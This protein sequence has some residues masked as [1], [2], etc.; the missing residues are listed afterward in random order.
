MNGDSMTRCLIAL[1][2]LALPFGAAPAEEAAPPT[3]ADV[4]DL[5]RDLG[6]PYSGVR[7][8]AATRL[9]QLGPD[10][11]PAV[12]ALWRA[13]R[14]DV[15]PVREAALRALLALGEAAAKPLA[16][17]L[18]DPAHRVR[19]EG[20]LVKEAG[21][22]IVPL[23]FALT[24][25][26]SWYVRTSALA[27][28]SRVLPGNER[29]PEVLALLDD[30]SA[31]VRLAALR[32]V[33]ATKAEGDEVF[34]ALLAR[35]KDPHVLVRQAVL[36]VIGAMSEP[37]DRR[38]DLL[39]E[40]ARDADTSH[41]HAA[42]Y[43]LRERGE[44]DAVLAAFRRGLRDDSTRSL[45]ALALAEREQWED[46]VAAGLVAGLSAADRH[47]WLMGEPFRWFS[48]HSL[49][50][51]GRGA[52]LPLWA[53]DLRPVSIDG[54]SA[55]LRTA[56]KRAAAS[57]IAEMKAKEPRRK[58]NAIWLL[59][60]IGGY[61]PFIATAFVDEAREV[62]LLAAILLAKKRHDLKYTPG[63]LVRSLHWR[64]TEGENPYTQEDRPPYA[65]YWQKEVDAAFESLGSLAASP[66]AM[67]LA[68]DAAKG[69]FSDPWLYRAVVTLGPDAKAV[70]PALVESWR[71]AKEPGG[72]HPD[73]ESA[74]DLRRKALRAIGAGAAPVIE[75]RLESTDEGLR[76][77]AKEMLAV[78]AEQDD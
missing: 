77:A 2:L 30:S 43:F 75:G 57:L 42:L 20:V 25:D 13:I 19:F 4:P 55:A 78:L 74:S 53:R 21:R 22:P 60:R 18:E 76:E 69:H 71:Y 17:W 31:A 26:E 68:E 40:A 27:G 45:C 62:R 44:G 37:A 61:E 10:A 41:R 54:I 23:L 52:R 24:R 6:D 33:F 47:R 70:V 72:I 11:A 38:R 51:R 67:V 29:M 56:G 65:I 58:V 14:S 9:G 7:I 36:S 16:T 59:D 32:V 12:D 1:L 66:L 28:L 64:R 39:L 48:R 63:V 46:G 15:E 49:R 3:P 8:R 50:A 34:S 73:R 5:I 35:W